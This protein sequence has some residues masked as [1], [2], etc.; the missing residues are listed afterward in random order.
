MTVSAGEVIYVLGE[1]PSSGVGLRW[2]AVELN[3]A[4]SGRVAAVLFDDVGRA[5]LEE[6][7]A[8]LAETDFTQDRLRRVLEDPKQVETWRVGE[9]IAETYLTDHRSCTF[10]WPDGRDE[11]KSGSSLPGADLI[12]FGIDDA[13]DCLAFGEVKT[14]SECNYPPGTMYGPTG[15]KQQ[16]E[17]LR[18]DECIQK[19]LV[20]YLA[21]RAVSAPWKAR[22]ELAAS[23][24]LRNTSDF[25]LY[26]FL[27]R[28][29]EPHLDDLRVRVG[30]L[31]VGCPERTCIELLALYLP[32]DSLGDIGEK[33][34]SLRAGVER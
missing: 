14:S 17:D 11:R 7:L 13:G 3:D 33:M 31:G 16:L 30:D 10:P 32:Q 27:V 9:A 26:G 28:D 18:D 2:S 8:G 22:F 29:V 5:N 20:K 34:I 25:Q 1:P 24:Y 23:R 6:I 12:G 21:H 15:L 4:M 19:G